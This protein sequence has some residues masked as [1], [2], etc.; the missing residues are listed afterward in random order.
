VQGGATLQDQW[1]NGLAQKKIAEGVWTHVV[2]QGQSL[3]PLYW[4]PQ[5]PFFDYAQQLGDLIVAAGARPTF[6]V[7]WARAAGDAIYGPLP[8][9]A[10]VSPRQMQDELNIGYTQVADLWTDSLLVCAGE[11]FQRSIAAYP[12]IALQQSDLSHPTVAGTY[13]AASTFYVALTGQPVPSRSEVPEGLAAEDA[14]SLRAVARDVGEACAHSRLEGG[15]LSDTPFAG[16]GWPPI[17]FGTTAVPISHSFSITN[18]GGLVVGIAD[19]MS[20]APPFVWTAG[21]AYPGGS[22]TGFCGS[23]LAP[24]ESCTVSVSYTG[25]TTAGGK[26]TLSFTDAYAPSA[27]WDLRGTTT[28]RAL[29]VV[30]DAP[31]LDGCTDSCGTSNVTAD[32]FSTMPPGPMGST[33]IFVMNRGAR[34]VT[35]LGVGL[36]LI[37]PF[38]WGGGAFPGG[39]GSVT[40]GGPQTTYPYCSAAVLGV[41]EQCAL[42]VTFSP[43]A[44]ATYLAAVNLTYADALGPVLPNANRN[45]EGLC[46]SLPP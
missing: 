22:G 21:G 32:C 44:T 43:P 15:I 27:T 13:L 2:L 36:P 34:P 41:G 42:T 18:V 16:E 39:T 11:A 19:G 14:A 3:E 30:S 6:F 10:F 20:L 9:G 5:A 40:W 45:L 25:A 26:L 17:D 12:K 8:V 35:A 28:D 1:D 29:L 38:A 7:T 4:S 31:G 37:A 23:S 46:S 24:G 33:T